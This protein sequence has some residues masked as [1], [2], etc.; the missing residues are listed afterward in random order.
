MQVLK[1]LK[2]ALLALAII[3][4]FVF[5]IPLFQLR[6]GAIRKIW[7]KNT[8]VALA[9]YEILPLIYTVESEVYAKARKDTRIPACTN[10][11]IEVALHTLQICGMAECAEFPTLT[12]EGDSQIETSPK[13]PKS[14]VHWRKI[15]RGKKQ[16]NSWFN[17]KPI[18]G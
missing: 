6:L 14:A 18:P 2:S 13:V 12:K 15:P 3:V 1:A 16:K 11:N 7:K 17:L 5:F 4:L 9:D 8:E 10:T